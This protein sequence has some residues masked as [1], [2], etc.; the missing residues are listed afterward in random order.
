MMPKRLLKEKAL[1]LSENRLLL[2]LCFFQLLNADLTELFVC[3]YYVYTSTD[4]PNNYESKY[5]DSL[6]TRYAPVQ[7]RSLG[8][9][10]FE[11]NQLSCEF[12]DPDWI[13]HVNRIL[14]LI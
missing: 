11:V 1:S 2:K 10:S 3:A 8:K 14:S 12:V 4:L 9:F 5:V 6:V 13:R 7:L